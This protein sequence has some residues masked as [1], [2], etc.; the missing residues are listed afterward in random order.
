VLLGH[1]YA[2]TVVTS[3]A[4]RAPERIV[5]LVYLD[6]ELEPTLHGFQVLDPRF[7]VVSGCQQDPANGLKDCEVCSALFAT[8]WGRLV[9]SMVKPKASHGNLGTRQKGWLLR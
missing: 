1:I 6:T 9:H 3:T 2:G 8:V 7:A 4:D 5:Q